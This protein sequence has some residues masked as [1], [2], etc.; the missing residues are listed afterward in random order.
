MRG[1]IWSSE[2]VGTSH[3]AKTCALKRGRVP[4][5]IRNRSIAQSDNAQRQYLRSQAD[6]G[7]IAHAVRL[8]NCVSTGGRFRALF[9]SDLHLGKPLFHAEALLAFLRCHQADTIYLLGDI[10]NFWH[11][12]RR[13]ADWSTAHQAVLDHLVTLAQSGVRICYLPGN[14]DDVLRVS[15]NLY[16]HG[17]QVS[18]TQV[19][20]CLD[21]QRLLVIHGD[22]YDV[23]LRFAR[24]H[25]PIGD[26]LYDGTLGLSLALKS[27]LGRKTIRTSH[28]PSAYAK[29]MFKALILK[30]SRFDAKVS[31]DLRLQGL[32]GIVCGHVHHAAVRDM[33]GLIYL[34]SGDW[35][36]SCTA[37]AERQDGTLG[38]LLWEAEAKSTRVSGSDRMRRD[39]VS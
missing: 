28:S 14:H 11:L 37:V 25:G 22:Q 13:S 27:L 34:I 18:E 1:M 15:S 30:I 16:F 17:I 4:L 8:F 29:W 36:E 32:H 12:S 6:A 5:G 39:P 33:G 9:L 23:V 21:G 7:G 20:G 24:W 26:R 10:I 38:V 2:H 35:M 19:H 3:D 31:A